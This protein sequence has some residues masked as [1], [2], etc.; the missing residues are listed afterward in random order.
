VKFNKTYELQIQLPSEVGK[1]GKFLAIRP[2]VTV[3][4][5]IKRSVH[6]QSISADIRIYNL[7]ED[8]RSK[9]F[10]DRYE[11]YNAA[12]PVSPDNQPRYVIFY[13]GYE[14]DG[15]PLAPIFIGAIFYASSVRR[16]P[17]YITML[18]CKDLDIYQYIK[19]SSFTIKKDVDKAD[20]IKRLY[21]DLLGFE[22]ADSGIIGGFTGVA[23]R[24]RAYFGPTF[25]ILAEVTEGNFYM[26]L[27][28][29]ISLLPGE[30]FD[31]PAIRVLSAETGLLNVPMKSATLAVA[32]LIFTPHLQV[33][34][35]VFVEGY[36]DRQYNGVYKTVSIH[37][38]GVISGTH[39]TQ[40][41]TKA[42]LFNGKVIKNISPT[43]EQI[44]N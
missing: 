41:T 9:I 7:S 14:S 24:G 4:F 38:S 13:A 20:V 19:T 39:D 21:E 15:M 42:S 29:P 31:N 2:P 26:E 6:A 16:G 30:T 28:K 5:V 43:G 40:T 3:E 35:Y 1:V 17:N 27:G 10:R 37:H 23:E 22:I 11:N 36:K 32:D 8:T 33:G 44:G 12:A 34:Q 25:D 18:E